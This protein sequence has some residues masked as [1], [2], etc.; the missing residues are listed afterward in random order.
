MKLIPVPGFVAIL[1]RGVF[2]ALPSSRPS[3]AMLQR[4][5]TTADAVSASA[6]AVREPG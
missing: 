3:G 5:V 2:P 6:I 4:E 1:L